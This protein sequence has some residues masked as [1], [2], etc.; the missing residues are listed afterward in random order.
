MKIRVAFISLTV[1]CVTLAAVPA[2][3]QVVY[4]NGPM[5]GNTDAW[6]VSSG[7]IVSDTLHCC[8]EADGSY[9]PGGGTI[10]G[11]NFYAWLFPG[12]TLSTAELSIT[13]GENSGTSFFDQ[14][15]SFTQGSCASNGFGFSVCLESSTF[16]GPSLAA[17]T[18]WVNLQNASVPSGDPVYWDENSGVGCGGMGCPSQASENT[19]GSI[20]SESFTVFGVV[21]TTSTTTSTTTSVPEPSSIMLFGSGG[22]GLA[23]WLR[24]KFF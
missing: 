24:R 15:V 3:A 6:T 1:V 14:T 18:Y 20:P 10:D 16:S 7:F 13:S 19:V 8:R 2:L 21:N 17:G 11:F 23:A 22:L 5:N 4:D 9:A 12:D